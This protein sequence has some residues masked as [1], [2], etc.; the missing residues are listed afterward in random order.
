MLGKYVD[1]F[2]KELTKDGNSDVLRDCRFLTVGYFLN[3]E[4][5]TRKAHKYFFIIDFLRTRT[6][7]ILVLF[8]ALEIVAVNKTDKATCILLRLKKG[9]QIKAQKMHIG[10]I[11]KNNIRM[12]IF[13]TFYKY[14]VEFPKS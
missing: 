5:R 12:S 4:C 1:T 13:I 9:R 7:Y 11:S 6:Y 8:Q 3:N 14:F 10:T 2:L